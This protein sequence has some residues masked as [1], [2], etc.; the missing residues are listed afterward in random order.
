MYDL[1]QTICERRSVRGFLPD[2]P[3]PAATIRECLELAQRAPSNCNVQPWRVFLASGAGCERLRRTLAEAIGRGEMPNPEDEQ[4]KFPPPYRRLQ[5]DCAVRMYNEMGIGRDDHAGR[6]QAMMRNFELFDAPH[7]AIVCMEKYYGL[8]VALDVGMWVQTF[9]LALWSRG[10]QSCPQASLRQYPTI[11]KSV[12]GIP[13]ELR[14][15][16]GVTF[17]YEDPAVPANR[18]RQTREPIDANV[19]FVDA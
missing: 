13:D 12:L 1:D 3:V 10:V 4:D 11:F 5:V 14:M 2:R 17:G 19:V 7:V 8:G 18:T 15:L 6:M 16:C 9:M